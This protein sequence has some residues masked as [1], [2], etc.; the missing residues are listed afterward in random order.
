MISATPKFFARY[1]NVRFKLKKG[2]A[3]GI[4]AYRNGTLELSPEL[5]RPST[6]LPHGLPAL[7]P[8]CLKPGHPMPPKN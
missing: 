5:Y 3:K 6:S 1:P 8:L 7:H 2:S 4:Y